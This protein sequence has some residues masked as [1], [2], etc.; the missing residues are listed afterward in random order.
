MTGNRQLHRVLVTGATGKLGRLMC[1]M[2]PR[3]IELVAVQRRP[4]PGAIVWDPQAG[5]PPAVTA[6][7]VVALWG[8]VPGRGA[9]LSGNLRL[10]R[11]AEAL[12]RSAGAA[13]VLH[14][15]SVAV[16]APGRGALAETAPLDPPDTYGRAKL[17]MERWVA[18]HTRPSGQDACCLR[19]G[20]VAGAESL[21]GA[22]RRRPVLLDRFGD[23]RG[24]LRS[25]IAPSHLVRVILGLLRAPVLPL[26]LNVAAPRPVA[27]PDL[28]TAMALP[29][30][31]RPAPRGARQHAVLDTGALA[32]LVNL[33][34]CA[35]DPAWIV[36]DVHAAGWSR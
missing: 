8:V 12:A 17:E 21:F 34:A 23:G 25:Y 32:R 14:C 35:Y 11:A 18:S 19:I 7:A 29:W 10:A 9:D 28:A 27:M 1:A 13:R 16:Y 20:S 33:P 31:W 22:A 3:G 26:V 15:S 30:R 4:G 6:D 5:P 24:T 2:A 36:R